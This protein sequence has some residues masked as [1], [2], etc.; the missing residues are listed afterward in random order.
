MHL[1]PVLLLRRQRQH[2][3]DIH[4]SPPAAQEQRCRI[5]CA[6]TTFA[7]FSKTGEPG[8]ERGR[9]PTACGALPHEQCYHNT[10]PG[11]EQR[12]HSYIDAFGAILPRVLGQPMQTLV[13]TRLDIPGVYYPKRTRREPGN[14]AIT[15][16]D[17]K[18]SGTYEQEQVCLHHNPAAGQRATSAAD[19][20]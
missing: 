4:R 10:G 16:A 15:G 2:T 5:E 17:T 7:S 6:I 12:I 19:R 1:F 20:I 11:R 14:A 13:S 9:A 3:F 18:D 8:S